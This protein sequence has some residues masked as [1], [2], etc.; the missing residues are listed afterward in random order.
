M[1]RNSLLFHWNWGGF[2]LPS[3][4]GD[5]QNQKYNYAEEKGKHKPTP[6]ML[7]NIEKNIYKF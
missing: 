4:K 7:K 3:V 2:S 6:R 5:G 1:Y